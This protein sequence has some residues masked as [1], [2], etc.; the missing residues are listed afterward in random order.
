MSRLKILDG[1]KELVLE[2]SFSISEV[3]EAEFNIES[4]NRILAKV[5]FSSVGELWLILDYSATNK[6]L[7]EYIINKDFKDTAI[8]DLGFE[9]VKDKEISEILHVKSTTLEEDISKISIEKCIVDSIYEDQLTKA[10]RMMKNL[11]ILK[12]YTVKNNDGKIEIYKGDVKNLLAYM[13]VHPTERSWGNSKILFFIFANSH[14]PYPLKRTELES[15]VNNS[16][17]QNYLW[18]HVNTYKSDS[19]DKDHIHEMLKSVKD[20]KNPKTRTEREL[21]EARIHETKYLDNLDEYGWP[22][23]PNWLKNW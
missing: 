17:L 11:L 14:L 18:L 20:G 8:S 6:K 16:I 3:N 12:G 1:I 23:E 15:F 19:H 2:A 10:C 21:F 4:D 5:G 9:L 7:Y 22:K 13:G